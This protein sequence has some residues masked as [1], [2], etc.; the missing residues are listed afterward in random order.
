MTGPRRRSPVKPINGDDVE[1]HYGDE[2]VP[3]PERLDAMERQVRILKGGLV[4]LAVLLVLHAS[5]VPIYEVFPIL[6]RLL[7]L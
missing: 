4:G 6:L 2:V 5:G 7:G 3:L 1:I